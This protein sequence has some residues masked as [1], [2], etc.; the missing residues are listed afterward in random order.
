MTTPSEDICAL[1]KHFRMKEHPEHAREG[2]G[3]CMGYEGT[4]YGPKNPF[5]SWKT[6]ACVHFRQDYAG[7]EARV[8][9]I[10]RRRAQEQ[11]NNAVQ[12]EMKG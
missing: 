11:N 7:T 1:R 8:A 12:T 4:G 5:H 2:L 3:R 10:E 9:W 6:K